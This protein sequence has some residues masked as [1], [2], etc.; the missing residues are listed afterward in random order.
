VRGPWRQVP[1]RFSENFGSRQR[2]HASIGLAIAVGVAYFLAARLSLFLLSRPDGVA[3]FWPAA[4]IS[5]GTLIALRRN[6]RWPVAVG[7]IAATTAANLTSDRTIWAS[8]VFALCD[9]G[10]ALLTAW[11]VERYVGAFSLD[12]LRHVLWLLAGAIIGTATAG[13]A[14]A[15][16]YKLLYSPAVPA[17]ITWWH[18]FSSDAIG[19]ITTAPLIIG[20][21]SVV[22]APPP[23]REVIEGTA[24]LIAVAAVMIT[25]IFVFP[26]A[27]WDL[28]VP[29]ELLF[30]L[31]LWIGARCRPAF[32]AA[33]VF[34]LSLVIACTFIFRLGHFSDIRPSIEQRIFATQA[35]VLGVAIFAYILAALFA[36]RRQQAAVM[37]ESENRMRAIVDTVVD[38]IIT[39]DDQGTIE[40]LNPAAARIFGYNLEEVIGSN[41]RMLMP[42]PFRSEHAR[43]LVNYLRT[44]QAKII[45]NG[46]ELTG[47]RKDCSIFPMELAI[48]EMKV[49]GRRLFTGIVRDITERKLAEEHQKTLTSE[50][51]HRTN[52]LLTVIQIIANRTLSGDDALEGAK[53][54]LEARLRALARANKQLT[55]LDW[56][57][58]T[59]SEIIKS[60][61]EP[62]L[63]RCE[64][65]GTDIVLG[66]L[67]AQNF[68]LVL[69]ELATNAIKYGALSNLEGRVHI[70]WGTK[71]NGSDS[72]LIFHWR[73][74][75][76][77]PVVAPKRQGFGSTLLRASF[78]NV[79][80]NFD[81][82]GFSCEIEVPL[83]EVA[84]SRWAPEPKTGMGLN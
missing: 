4:G 17:V 82:N 39:I 51:Q 3:V 19:I 28:I 77:P 23:R 26:R 18:W 76:G 14:A 63:E 36:E 31:L 21:V 57:G 55:E 62:Y 70:T 69:H 33:A 22:R 27:W 68:S 7:V 64:I 60:G 48:S 38:G 83:R 74:Q 42:E 45:G 29:V 81:T 8:V 56:S 2:W 40:S 58:L 46:R 50:L 47:E 12:K 11:V 13:V 84:P 49:A 43:Y 41:V 44:G 79:R 71:G 37:E 24:A 80:S 15:V 75:G 59:L 52:N 30:P 73:E 20:V 5:S 9:T 65:D 34:V 54:I 6:A 35:A 16:G 72:Q 67:Y 61:L 78:A 1:S 66:R 53:E 32:T 10:E 25:I